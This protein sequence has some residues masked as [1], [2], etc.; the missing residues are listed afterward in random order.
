[1]IPKPYCISDHLTG[2]IISDHL[3]G[4]IMRLWLGMHRTWIDGRQDGPL[5]SGLHGGQRIC[6]SVASALGASDAVVSESLHSNGMTFAVG[7]IVS[8]QGALYKM[9]A[10][11]NVDEKLMVLDQPLRVA[12][13]ISDAAS[14]YTVDHG[15][16][17]AAKVNE[18]EAFAAHCWSWESETEVLVLHAKLK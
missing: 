2:A 13:S 7:D 11:A 10:C 3:P 17:V 9:V 4:A 14:L 12:R 8:A 6:P 15:G 5:H 1:M 16:L 18:K